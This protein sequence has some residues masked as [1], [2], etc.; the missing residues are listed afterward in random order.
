MPFC[1]NF[2]VNCRTI[3]SSDTNPSKARYK[4]ESYVFLNKNIEGQDNSPENFLPLKIL[5][6]MSPMI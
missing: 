5:G 4:E 3:L 2:I 1:Y 6:Q